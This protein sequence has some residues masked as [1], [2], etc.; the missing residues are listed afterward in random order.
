M[1]DCRCAVCTVSTRH[2]KGRRRSDL[3]VG[4]IKFDFRWNL[5][6][7]RFTKEEDGAAGPSRVA[8]VSG[9]AAVG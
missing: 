5:L 8:G 4:E 7:R 6:G 3:D 9:D 1:R 2:V